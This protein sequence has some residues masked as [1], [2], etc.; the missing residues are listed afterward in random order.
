MMERRVPLGMAEDGS[1]RSPDRLA[2]ATIPVTAVKNT[3]KVTKKSGLV[4]S[5]ESIQAGSQ[6]C[7]VVS[8]LHPVKP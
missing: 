2:P 1:F 4:W 5:F 8:Q 7:L 3:P 6:F